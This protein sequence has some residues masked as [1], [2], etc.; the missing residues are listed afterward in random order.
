MS[1]FQEFK[2]EGKE[3]IELKNLLKVTGVCSSGGAAKTAIE[4]G[5]VTVDGL[6]ETRKAFKV[7]AGHTVAHEGNTIKVLA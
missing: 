6:V 2:L 5:S 3:Y 7:R 1:D 4:F